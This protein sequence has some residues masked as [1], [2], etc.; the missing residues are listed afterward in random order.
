MAIL[1]AVAAYFVVA[2]P[3]A[4]VVGRALRS[5]GQIGGEPVVAYPAVAEPALL[6]R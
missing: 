4:V 1:V 5:G 6:P 3:V 2:M